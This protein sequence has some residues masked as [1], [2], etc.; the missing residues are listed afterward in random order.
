MT[1][2]WFHGR[3]PRKCGAAPLVENLLELNNL[4]H[5]LDIWCRFRWPRGLRRGF[6]ATPFLGL[7]VRIPPKSSMSVN[8]MCCQLEV[9]AT[10]WSLIQRS[11]TECGVSECDREASI[12]RPSLTFGC[13]AMKRRRQQIHQSAQELRC[14]YSILI[15]CLY[16]YVTFGWTNREEWDGSG[17]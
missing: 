9:S 13:C 7:R 16:M 12:M 3:V 14:W 2:S 5:K 6:A 1:S 11:F 15:R 17:M 10:E 8:V 4:S